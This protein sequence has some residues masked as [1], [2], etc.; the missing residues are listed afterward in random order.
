MSLQE[1][2]DKKRGIIPGKS[3]V[4][5]VKER[6]K[7]MNIQFLKDVSKKDIVGAGSKTL[8]NSF[9]YNSPN[10]FYSDEEIIEYAVSEKF[11]KRSYQGKFEKLNTNF[12]DNKENLFSLTHK[13]NYREMK[14]EMRDLMCIDAVFSCWRQ[15]KQ[16]Y[17]FDKDFAEELTQ[18]ENVRIPF[19]VF[20]KIPYRCFYKK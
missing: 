13:N 12:L 6:V 9:N 14:T 16:T 1:E 17:V 15:Y 8:I 3:R 4:I 5:P 20:H 2:A 11:L 18:T 7:K 19:T 10:N